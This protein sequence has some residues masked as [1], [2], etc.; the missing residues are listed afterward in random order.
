MEDLITPEVIE[1]MNCPDKERMS[2]R[3]LS[4]LLLHIDMI[5]GSN[6]EF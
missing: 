6:Y 1:E 2:D 3:D 5:G 4:L